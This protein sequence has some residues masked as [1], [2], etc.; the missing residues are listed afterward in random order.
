MKL[1]DRITLNR[2]LAIILGFIISLLK[3][4]MPKIDTEIDINNPTPPLPKPPI[5]KR[6]RKKKESI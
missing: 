1:L 2:T 4:F 6:G 3:I 5:W